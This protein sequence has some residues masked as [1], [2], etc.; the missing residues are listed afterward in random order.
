MSSIAQGKR[1][2]PKLK[3]GGGIV[4]AAMEVGRWD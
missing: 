3:D 1:R 2:E 4:F